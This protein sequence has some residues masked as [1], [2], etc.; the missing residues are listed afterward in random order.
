MGKS[1]DPQ[2]VKKE[3]RRRV[4]SAARVAILCDFDGTICHEVVIDSLYALFAACGLEYAQKWE[5]GEI[6]TPEEITS[7]FATITASREEMEAALNDFTVDPGIHELLAFSRQHGYEFAVVS[8]GLDW[9]IR[10]I[11][12]RHGVKDVS[13]FANQIEF[14][15]QGFQFTFPW[16]HALTPMRGVSKPWIVQRYRDQ[17][18]KVAVIG[19]G[20]TDVEAAAV[21][22]RVYAQGLLMDYCRQH[23]IPAIEVVDLED[24]VRKW[25]NLKN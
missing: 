10:H 16:R 21:A 22:D 8:D 4:S 25:Q 3:V 5:R 9:Y 12:E 17:G 20:L 7:S 6:T 11:L 2:N 15:P 1:G 18:A 19:D 13:I 23:G 24:V 14:T